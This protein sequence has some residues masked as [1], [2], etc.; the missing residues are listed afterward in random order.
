M[1]ASN[2]EPLG[3]HGTMV[4]KRVPSYMRPTR[5]SMQK[6][7]L[8]PKFIQNDIEKI[9]K[10]NTKQVHRVGSKVTR[11]SM[12]STS[13][14]ATIVDDAD[15]GSKTGISLEVRPLSLEPVTC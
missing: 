11:L 1:A 7:T 5:T 9:K 13:S 15:D 3:P 14:S 6:Q 12:P 10:G 2:S 4:T 8:G